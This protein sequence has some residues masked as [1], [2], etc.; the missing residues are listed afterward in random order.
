MNR[1]PPIP[2]ELRRQAFPVGNGELFWPV[3]VADIVAEAIAA[4]ELGIWGGEVY[5]G[6]GRT[7]GNMDLEWTTGPGWGSEEPWPRY[8]RRGLDQAQRAIARTRRLTR[9]GEL[10]SGSERGPMCFFA[11]HSRADYPSRDG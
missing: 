11:F 2:D 4:A 9:A 10:A 8:V 3:S 7:W 5:V 6:R 1:F